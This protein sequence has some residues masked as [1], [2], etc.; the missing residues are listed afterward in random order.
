MP[1]MQKM[2][3]MIKMPEMLKM[4]KMPRKCVML[5]MQPMP[6]AIGSITKG[7][8]ITMARAQNGGAAVLPRGV[9][10]RR[11]TFGG[12]KRARF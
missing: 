9:S 5:E 7:F 11:P 2:Q 4:P 1:S 3:K 10:I 8:S 6:K 12:A